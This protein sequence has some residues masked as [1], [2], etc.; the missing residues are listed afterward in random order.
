MKFNPNNHPIFIQDSI[1]RCVVQILWCF[2]QRGTK[3]TAINF[4]KSVCAHWKD[5]NG[6]SLIEDEKSGRWGGRGGRSGLGR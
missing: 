6:T 3:M 2:L 5:E 1:Q 4:Q